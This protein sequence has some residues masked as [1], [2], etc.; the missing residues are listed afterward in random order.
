M[1]K[2]ISEKTSV[3]PYF[4]YFFMYICTLATGVLSFQKDLIRH[5]GY[6]AWISV[7]VTGVSI[8]ILVWMMYQILSSGRDGHDIATVHRSLFGKIPGGCLNGALVLYFVYGAFVKYELYFELIQ[9]WLFPVMN[10]LPL[11]IVT[12]MLIYYIVSGGFRSLAG[13]CVWAT[14]ISFVSVIPQVFLILPYAHPLNLLP[15][16]N[17]SASDL[18]M[19]SKSMTFDYMGYET[20][21]L[22]YPFFNTPAKS[23]KWAHLIIL[24]DTMLY[25]TILIVSLMFYPESLLRKTLW[26]T[27]KMI[28][29]YEIPMIQRLEYIFISI[30]FIKFISGVAIYIWAACRGLKVAFRMGGRISLIVMLLAIVGL[31]SFLIG[32]RSISW[33]SGLYAEVGFYFLYAYIPFL[34]V[35][36]L[37]RKRL[38]RYAKEPK[39]T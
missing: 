34:F 38:A 1:S 32:Q 11:S 2:E 4:V 23:Q 19:A 5:A 31:N 16:L 21:L 12:A 39:P 35:C 9:A 37:I 6:N 28:S 30:W 10:V 29:I 27:L 3:S 8:H 18:L 33:I 7:I 22:L 36:I 26:P 13:I 24:T 17:H 20:L 15:L 25:L 14:F